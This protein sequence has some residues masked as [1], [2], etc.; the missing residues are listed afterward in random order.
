MKVRFEVKIVLGLVFALIV[1]S[2]ASA[3]TVWTYTG[4]TINYIQGVNPGPTGPNPC[5]CALDGTVVLNDSGQ[6]IAWSFTAGSHTLTNLN[7][8]A[9]FFPFNCFGCGTG[10][11]PS[12]LDSVPFGPAAWAFTITGQGIEL[13][14]K[15]RGSLL[16]ARDEGFTVGSNSFFLDVESDPGTWTETV[17]A[18]EPATGLFVGLGLAV[19]GLMRRRRKKPLEN[20]VWEK[21]G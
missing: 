9:A 20:A 6:A 8:S 5:G 17:A 21:L 11:V 13:D 14:S 19:F 3:D 4:N 18:A 2:A 16:D 12:S 1:A 7:S 10:N 15:W